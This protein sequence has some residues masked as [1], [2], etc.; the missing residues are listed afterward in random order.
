M[1][2]LNCGSCGKELKIS[3]GYTGA[4]WNTKAGD[5][6][7][8]GYEISLD[9]ECGRTYPIGNTRGINDFSPSKWMEE[10]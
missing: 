9:C 5:R 2:N 7:G 6:S 10:R 4:D 8:Y 3:V 1:K